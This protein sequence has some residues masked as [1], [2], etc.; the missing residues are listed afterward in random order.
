MITRT[1]PYDPDRHDAGAFNC[2]QERLDRWLRHYAGQSQ[3]RD[4]AR[5]FVLADDRDRIIGY[6]TT[7]VGELDHPGAHPDVRKGLSRYFPIPV[8]VIARLAVDAGNHQ[9]G[10]GALLLRDAAL[11]ILS[12]GEQVA[13][14]A[15][16]VHAIDGHAANFYAHFGFKP[17]STDPTTLMITTVEL[18]ESHAGFD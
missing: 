13:I 12:A 9:R 7:V 8:A 14:R 17:L 1:E 4:A 11:R 3:R 18:R 10:L 5:T 16:V 2:G 6:Y 15:V